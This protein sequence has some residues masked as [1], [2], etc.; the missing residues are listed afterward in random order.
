MVKSKKTK[1]ADVCTPSL[2]KYKPRLYLDLQ[3]KDVSKIKGL[4]IGEEG[5]FVIVGKI[6]GLSQRER[7]EG[8][9]SVKTGSIDV[10]D[11]TIEVMVENENEFESMA[12]DEEAD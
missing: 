3:D 8:K 9:E 6:V 10:E 5:K 1:V 2:C 12:A 11:Y 4:A 7:Q